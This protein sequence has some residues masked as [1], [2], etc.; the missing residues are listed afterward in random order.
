MESVKVIGSVERVTTKSSKGGAIVLM[1]EMP[2][3]WDKGAIIGSNLQR[4]AEIEFRFFDEPRKGE[5][6]DDYAVK[7]TYP[8]TFGD[9]AEVEKEGEEAFTDEPPA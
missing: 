3:D 4:R 9:D 2:T 1:V 6:A 5:D 7:Q 8:L